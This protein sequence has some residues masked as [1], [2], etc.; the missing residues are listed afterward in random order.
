MDMSEGTETG[1]S[2]R[3][4]KDSQGTEAVIKP[5]VL[6]AAVEDLIVLIKA[7]EEA[8]AKLTDAVKAIAEKSGYLAST[9]MKYAKAKAGEDFE[10]VKDKVTQ[11]ALAFGV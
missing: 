5:K 9:V 4:R 1:K 6:E 2:A 8:K 11:L 7:E 10:G 3:G